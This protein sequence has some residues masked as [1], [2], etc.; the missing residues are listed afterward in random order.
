MILSF[1][2]EYITGGD[3]LE[4]LVQI[5][6]N[7]D[8][9]RYIRK[10]VDS[11]SNV[12][13]NTTKLEQDIFNSIARYLKYKRNEGISFKRIRY[14][15]D[16]SIGKALK[17]HRLQQTVVYSDLAITN[18]FGESLEYEPEDEITDVGQ[19]VL[20]RTI[21]SSL[22]GKIARLAS[23]DFEEFVLQSWMLG[24]SDVEIARELALRKGGKVPSLVV[25]ISRFRERC[26]KRWTKETFV[27]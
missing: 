27:S 12:I 17:E 14:L 15:V 4:N 20:E 7:Y 10:K 9:L 25:K 3:I 18:G 22:K 21:E 24:D 11:V 1:T 19:D 6:K 16:S 8:V 26:K 2:E 23:D 5:Y 13:T